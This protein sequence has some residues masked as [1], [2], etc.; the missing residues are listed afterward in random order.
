MAGG[1]GSRLG[2][3]TRHKPKPAIKINE[4]P[5][6]LYLLD[7]LKKRGFKKIYII[8]SYKYP[9]IFD[10]IEKYT[11][12]EKRMSIQVLIDKKR[13]GTFTALMIIKNIIRGNFFYTNSDEINFFDPK[14]MYKEFINNK[15]NIISLIIK[16]NSG[17]LLI[18]NKNKKILL[19]KDNK[20]NYLELGCKFMNVKILNNNKKKFHKLE[21]FLYDHLI[22]KTIINYY[23]SKKMPIRIDTVKDIISAK[24]DIKNL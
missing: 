9:V 16:R 5:F 20:G 14:K 24:E 21:N 23:I 6:L 3:I 2:A 17:N 4:K 1:I 10:L 19:K 13:K 12:K 22:K 18:D 11:L 7:W 15:S 8:A